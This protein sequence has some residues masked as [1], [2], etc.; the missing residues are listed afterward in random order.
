MKKSIHKNRLNRYVIDVT[1]LIHW[2]RPPV[3]I[4]RTLHEVV[5]WFYH[6]LDNDVVSFVSFSED[7]SKI[8]VVDKNEIK[9][10][11]KKLEN[12][13]FKPTASVI[14]SRKLNEKI[15]KYKKLLPI[16]EKIDK[17]KFI[18]NNDS[19]YSIFKKAL[20]YFIKLMRF[21]KFYNN[22]IFINKANCVSQKENTNSS[23]DIIF[24]G[25]CYIGKFEETFLEKNDVFIS[26]GLDWDR[27]NYELLYHLKNRIGF[28]FVGICY[29]LIPISHPQ[30]IQSELFNQIFYKHIY[31]LNHLADKISCISNYSNKSLCEFRENYDINNSTEIETI[32]IGDN[33]NQK[34]EISNDTLIIEESK[35]YILYVST[36]ESRKN[37][38]TLLKAY[39]EAQKSNIILPNLILVGMYGWGIDEFHNLFMNNTYLQDKIKIYDTVDDQKLINLYK[40][41]LFCVFPSY[42]EGWGLGAAES[43][44]YGKVCLISE[45]EALKE[46][47]QYLMPVIKSDN[48]LEWMRSIHF[49]STHNYEREKLEM[50]I[51]LN[52]KPRSWTEFCED[53]YEFAKGNL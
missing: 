7:K 21:D 24:S 42:V 22:I 1:T 37:H 9:S 16:K 17:I 15:Q 23:L 44:L 49:Y 20:R 52:F 18:Y 40:N 19:I 43:L 50:D 31:Y 41:S 26:L 38:S 48:P 5:K 51:K 27:S 14:T 25:S 35:P 8:F 45:S 39:L 34:D 10:L 28:S 32:Y 36:I 46:A 4:I 3:G 6:N 53:F 11:L 2:N 29:D 13:S 30:H 33:L 47:T 12:T